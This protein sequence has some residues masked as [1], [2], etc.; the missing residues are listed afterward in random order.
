MKK[1]ELRELIKEVIQEISADTPLMD[2]IRAAS[3]GDDKSMKDAIADLSEID[4][5]LQ[6]AAKACAQLETFLKNNANN[7]RAMQG[8]PWND[9]V[10]SVYYSVRD[11]AQKLKS[12]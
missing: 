6:Y 12:Q 3:S 2:K 4:G 1:S 5:K 8:K 10:D 11:V 9:Y 7:T